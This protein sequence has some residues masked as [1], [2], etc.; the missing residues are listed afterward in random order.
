MS[1]HKN[2]FQFEGRDGTRI[3]AYCWPA[4]GPVRGVLQIA[5]GMGEHARRYF[6]PLQKLRTAGIAIYANDHRGHGR[7]A[8]NAASLGDFGPGGF[9]AVVDDMAALSEIA[10]HE[11]PEKPLIL[12]G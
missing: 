4:V 9:G 8:P 5:H 6:A 3:V 12:L 1:E 10:R 7:T 11:H 2:L